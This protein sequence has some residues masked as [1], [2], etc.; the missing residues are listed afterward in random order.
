MNTSGPFRKFATGSYFLV[1]D[2]LVNFVIG[3]IFWLVLAKMVDPVWIGQS[4]VVV[5]FAT[6]IIGFL[7]YG[8]Q[9]TLEKYISEYNARN[10]P[11][12]SRRVLKSAIKMS[13]I[14]SGG[15]AL[16][17]TLIS[18]QIATTAYH[19][20]S[21]SSLLVLIMLTYFPSQTIIAVLV[22][23]FVGAHKA[24]YAVLGDFIFQISR[25]ALVAVAVM[26]LGNIGAFGILVSFSIASGLALAISY[27]YSLPRA[28]PRL[29]KKDGAN[30]DIRHLIKF[31]GLN[32]IAVGL[33]TATAQVGVLIL[34]TQNFEWAAF[35]GLAALLSKVVGA[36]SFSVSGALLP[37]ASEQLV[38]GD[39]V[40]LSKMINTAIRMSIFISGFS[41]TILLLEPSYF[42]KLISYAYV[43]GAFALRILVI[44]SMNYAL[45]AIFTS[46]LNASNRT[47]DV[48]KIEIVSSVIVIVLT[49]ILIPTIGLEGAALALLIGSIC[50]LLLAVVAVKREQKLTISIAN[51]LKP[52][53][54]IAVALTLGYIFIIAVDALV[55]LVATIVSYIISS[56]VYGV[57]KKNEL[58]ELFGIVMHSAK[59]K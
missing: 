30:E 38:K 44:I 55:G 59:S 34:A 48:A 46:L 8:V 42:L 50:S 43:G 54:P 18:P 36:S 57:I 24:K 20:P 6:T 1:L 47:V 35:Y 21:I 17:I 22:G 7:G 52:I 14:M 56:L 53:V 28:L 2:N 16:V 27:F 29:E 12:T 58:R 4:M 33:R 37:A 23:A 15:V 40:E 13:L 39:K 26:A 11:H 32:Y 31:S 41:F 49:F 45:S 51:V 3:A 25:I 9:V 10:M 19:D 5:A